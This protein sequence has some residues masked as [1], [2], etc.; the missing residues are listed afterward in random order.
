MLGRNTNLDFYHDPLPLEPPRDCYPRNNDVMGY[1]ISHIKVNREGN[2]VKPDLA[3]FVKDI[4]E[5]G[6]SIPKS[7]LCIQEKFHGLYRTYFRCRCEGRESKN[8]HKIKIT[9]VP[10][11]KL[12]R[13]SNQLG[14]SKL[15]STIDEVANVGAFV[16]NTEETDFVVAKPEEE[17]SVPEASRPTKKP[18]SSGHLALENPR[19]VDEGRR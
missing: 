3:L 6:N 16:T 5:K 19:C 4:W 8:S 7:Y 14:E 9:A 12:T 17:H 10:P 18:R 1:Y 2:A 11:K 13:R 15:I